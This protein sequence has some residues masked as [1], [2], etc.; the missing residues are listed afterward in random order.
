MPAA[1][2]RNNNRT[3]DPI[4][5]RVK[6]LVGLS[7]DHCNLIVTN[8]IATFEDLSYLNFEDIDDSIP[9]VQRRKIDLIAKYLEATEKDNVYDLPTTTTMSSIRKYM[10]N[11]KTQDGAV[12]RDTR[13]V[14]GNEFVSGTPRVSTDPLEKFSGDPID[15]EEWHEATE[16]TLTQTNYKDLLNR[17]ATRGNAWELARNR[18]LFG[19]LYAA[20]RE[21]AAGN[22]LD[23][24]KEDTTI[25]MNGH[26]AWKALEAY[27][28]DASQMELMLEHWSTKL[29]N[30]ELD[31][32]TTATQFINS[33]EKFVRKLEQVEKSPWS[34]EKKIREFKKR[35]TSEEYDVEKRVHDDGFA[36]LINVF[37]KRERELE[38]EDNNDKVQRRFMRNDDDTKVEK[39]TPE[40]QGGS[41]NSNN[42]HGKNKVTIPFIPSFL[43]NSLDENAKVNIRK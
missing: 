1:T 38:K 16:N 15:F 31:D 2:R 39:F 17:D 33:F 23:K 32:D 6:G 20:V 5:D 13:G 19:F 28:L 37:R 22:I 11:K 29:D 12:A 9:V 3:E 27:Y 8:G 21:G 10:K 24:I 41:N 43:F 42:L 14:G 34:E 18:E 25:G 36:E 35:V 30:L 26:Q 40:K 7:D 4:N